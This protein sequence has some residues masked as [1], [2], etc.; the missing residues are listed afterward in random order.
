MPKSFCLLVGLFKGVIFPVNRQL[1]KKTEK[2]SE[3][4]PTSHFLA[5][6]FSP[7]SSLR[8]FTGGSEAEVCNVEV[9]V[10]GQHL[11]QVSSGTARKRKFLYSHS[12][13]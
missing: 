10:G 8:E 1:P 12:S 6:H 11:R 3:D 9:Q 5:Q 4:T 7:N 13:I 2:D